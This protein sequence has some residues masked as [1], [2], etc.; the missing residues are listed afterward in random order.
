[1]KKCFRI[2]L[3][4]VVLV[5]PACISAK[6]DIPNPYDDNYVN[7]SGIENRSAWGTYNVHDPSIRKFGD[8]YYCY[9]TDA[10]YG[11]PRDIRNSGVK[12]GCIQVRR[13]VDL[14]H[15]EFLG[16]AFD[17]IPEEA[18]K[19]VEE[20]S[21]SKGLNSVWAP[22]IMEDKG[23]YRLYYCVSAFGRK[24]SYI[25]MAESKSP[26]GPWTQRGCVVK[27]DDRSVMNAI[28]PTVIDDNTDGR[29]WMI[30]GS[31][32][33]GIFALQLDKKTGLALK[34]GDLGRRIAIRANSAVDNM[35]APEV[36]Y[37]PDTHKYYLFT[38]YDP[39][40]TTYNIRVGV[41]EHP[42]GPYYD[43]CGKNLNDSINALPLL[44]APYRFE[45]NEGWGGLG[46]CTVFDDAAG[47]YFIAHQGR[48][49]ANN[50]LMDLHVRRIFFNNDGWPMASPERYAGDTLKEVSDK[51][52]VGKWE[53]VKLKKTYSNENLKDGQAVSGR[54]SSSDMNNSHIVSIGK[55]DV[56]HLRNG[57]FNINI[58]GEKVKYVKV[59][60]GHDWEKK[61]ETLLFTGINDNGL[62]I[63]GKKVVDD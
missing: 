39:L 55:V 44:T 6:R 43:F 28:D 36:I 2:L 30:Y 15:W 3:L 14:V 59:Y 9:S 29:R 20:S 50:M 33:G 22:F 12:V 42:E 41:A 61:C 54:L 25:G 13:S 5:L 19:W 38:S 63:W 16:W 31:Y 34:D 8:T 52:I 40:M 62:S 11:D 7:I 37:N 48:P 17:S 57:L 46:H 32:F 23:L 24:D 47:N 49:A 21:G 45:G 56:K 18:A 35:E 10:I 4:S 26:E 60:R 1:M 27:T 53:T 58:G 51:E